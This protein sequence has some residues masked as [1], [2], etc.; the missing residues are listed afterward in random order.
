MLESIVP[1]RLVDPS[2]GEELSLERVAGEF[3]K[4]DFRW[5]LAFDS[6]AEDQYIEL[7]PRNVITPFANGIDA[8]FGISHS[9]EYLRLTE[10]ARLVW[11]DTSGNPVVVIQDHGPGRVCYLNTCCH[12]CMSVVPV[13]SPLEANQ[14][15]RLLFKN[16]L[17]WLLMIDKDG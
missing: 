13:T 14:P 10:H 9:F 6:F 15:F 4:G 5:L 1:V 2:A 16:I 7:E 17:A 11:A 3:R 8:R 12:S